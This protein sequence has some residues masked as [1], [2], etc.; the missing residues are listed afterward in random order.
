V[1]DNFSGPKMIVTRFQ[2]AINQHDLD[3]LLCCLHPQYR[4]EK[5]LF[6]ESGLLGREQIR[7][8]WQK[9]FARV[10]DLQADADRWAVHDET[11]WTQ[12]CWH[13]RESSGDYFELSGTTL[14]GVETDSILWGRF[15]LLPTGQLNHSPSATIED[16][17]TWR[18]LVDDPGWLRPQRP[19]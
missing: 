12:W 17:A 1:G 8:Q 7:Q 15:S 3:G 14:F 16:L 19:R 9:L 10:P 11:V 13:G 2:Q 18:H 5:P 6:G 4:E